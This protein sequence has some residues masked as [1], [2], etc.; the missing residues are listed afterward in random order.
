[1][2]LQEKYI[3]EKENAEKADATKVVLSN[4]AY[5]VCEFLEKLMMQIA[6][7]RLK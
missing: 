6:N 4:D 7:W 5:A 2:T 1:M 3:S